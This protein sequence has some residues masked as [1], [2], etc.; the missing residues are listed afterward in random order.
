[1]GARRISDSPVRGGVC[2]GWSSSASVFTLS[3][4]R[5]FSFWSEL[6]V[7]V[8]SSPI[9]YSGGCAPEMHTSGMTNEDK[10]EVASRCGA[11][12]SKTSAARNYMCI[13]I[14]PRHYAAPSQSVG[15]HASPPG[16][17]ITQTPA[18]KVAGDGVWEGRACSWVPRKWRCRVVVAF[19]FHVLCASWVRR[20]FSSPRTLRLRGGVRDLSPPFLHQARAR[21]KCS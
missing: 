13:A 8:C 19:R 21:E 1:M 5:H 17:A 9:A 6:A 3:R 15:G 12:S 4:R 16:F 7:G 18:R 11:R 10:Y 20:R 14:W 2:F